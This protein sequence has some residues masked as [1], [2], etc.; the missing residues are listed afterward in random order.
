MNA[1]QPKER[2]ALVLL[3]GIG[4]QRPMATIRSFVNG[5]FGT[6]GDSKPDRL[7]ELFE[8][9]RLNVELD[10]VKV[11][12]YELYWA[13]HMHGSELIHIL[14]WLK[15]LFFTPTE[16]LKKMAG[17]LN[18][19]L[20]TKIRLYVVGLLF[21]LVA[22]LLGV[23]FMLNTWGW[24]KSA[25]G[26]GVIAIVTMGMGLV[27]R[28]VH[29]QM[30]TVIGDAAR[31]LDSA[32][33]NVGIRQAIRTECVHFLE[34]LSKS[35]DPA[36]SRIV[37][38]GHSLGSVI[39]YDALKLLWAKKKMHFTVS[40]AAESAGLLAWLHGGARP[41]AEA[42]PSPQRALFEQLIPAE[43]GDWKISDLVTVGSPL[44]HAPLLLA[45]SFAEFEHLK[46]QRELPTCPPQKDH[47]GKYCGWKEAPGFKL[48]HAA[49]FALVQWTN[50]YFASDP[51]GGPLQKI[52]GAGINDVL[53]CDAESD[54]WL[55][56]VRYWAKGSCPGSQ[57]F[58][59]AVRQLLEYPKPPPSKR[60]KFTRTQME[61]SFY[62]LA[63]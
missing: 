40:G 36:Y 12:C 23:N 44:A 8:L 18:K 39:A 35:D 45:E 49:P 32:P 46:E 17:H 6:S 19:N 27:L 38:I 26:V 16:E 56:H 4:E 9:R 55:N 21:L 47:K 50:F 22:L 37:V 60:P 53:L 48:H 10:K 30:I 11:D 62:F 58:Q 43:N 3:H 33:A 42:A 1:E 34:E 2:I 57:V 31:Y 28:Y 51:I 61:T 13:H 63:R 52:F 7:S 5:I 15:R 29:D 24:F 25:T 14:K 59:Q 20:Y 41:E 54:T